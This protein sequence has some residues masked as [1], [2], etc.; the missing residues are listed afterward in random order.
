MKAR[1]MRKGRRK[2]KGGERGGKIDVC[3]G[4]GLAGRCK[5]NQPGLFFFFFFSSLYLRAKP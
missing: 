5:T 2:E 1:G 3:S 4:E